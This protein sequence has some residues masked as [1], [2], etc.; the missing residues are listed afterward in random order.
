MP[1]EMTW[2]ELDILTPSEG[3]SHTKPEGERQIPYDITYL[4]DLKYG[5]DDLVSKTETDRGQ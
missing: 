5:T 2:M 4:G 3:D 1:S